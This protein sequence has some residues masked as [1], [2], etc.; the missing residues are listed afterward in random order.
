MADGVH[1]QGWPKE[2]HPPSGAVY[3]Q[4]TDHLRAKQQVFCDCRK[5]AETFGNRRE[6]RTRHF[7]NTVDRYPQG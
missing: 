3:D 2:D 5:G 4:I 1:L 7:N 6:V